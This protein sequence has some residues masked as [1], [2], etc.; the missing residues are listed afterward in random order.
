MK[1]WGFV[2]ALPSEYLVHVRRGEV[3]KRSSGQGATCFKWPRDSI[4]IVPTSLQ[5]LH[6]RADQVTMERVGVEVKGLAVYR[7]AEP[8]LA[9]RVLN[10]SYPER[11]QQKLEE[12]LTEMF[13]GAAR[14][15]IAN[16]TVDECLQK[17]KAALAVEL[18]REIA[19][20]VGASGHPADGTDRGWGVV[21][22]TIEIQE[23]RVM[24]QGV[25]ASMQ[26][27]YRAALEQKAREATAE[28]NRAIA[29]RE[30]AYHRSVEEARIE[31][32]RE[33]RRKQQ[34]LEEQEAQAATA[35]KEQAARAEIQIAEQRAR[36]E[37]EAAELRAKALE[38]QIALDS[39]REKA[40]RH[41]REAELAIAER[42]GRVHAEITM[43]D[44]QAQ[45]VASDAQ[46][47]VLT[48]QKL[49]ELAAA[50]GQRIGEVRITQMGGEGNPFSQLTQGVSAVL[51][52]VKTVGR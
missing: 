23:V 25:F 48:A 17:R 14:R 34:A 31:N 12:V 20:V 27:P 36:A 1:R 5:R 37:L 18:L 8:L 35:L 13:M 11:A 33:L 10:F 9:Y 3:R 16:L 38:A 22:D 28:A 51:A 7:I 15:L 52:M 39:V 40:E 2:K 41:R 21:I 49:P 43:L 32:E 42:E 45:L 44:A 26:A 4:A 24:S 19:P 50:I 46:A 47:K 6:F 29:L 30:H